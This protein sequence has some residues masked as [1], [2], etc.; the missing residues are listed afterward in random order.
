MYFLGS[1]EERQLLA[2]SASIERL[3]CPLLLLGLLGLLGPGTRCAARGALLAKCYMAKSLTRGRC[4]PYIGVYGIYERTR[5]EHPS[6]SMPCATLEPQRYVQRVTS[7]GPL[8]GKDHWRFPESL[9]NCMVSQNQLSPTVMGFVP[10]TVLGDDWEIN[11]S[12]IHSLIHHSS[13]IHLPST[14]SPS[15]Q[16]LFTPIYYPLII[17]T[18]SIH[19]TI[20]HSFT[21]H[22]FIHSLSI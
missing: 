4:S 19:P 11:E 20:Y 5:K 14:L 10:Q 15:I 6:P 21:I 8:K 12:I 16:H 1:D 13:S 17:Y 3:H 7:M 18:P 2:S 22:S 9:V